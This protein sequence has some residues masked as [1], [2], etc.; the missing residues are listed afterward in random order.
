MIWKIWIHVYYKQDIIINNA[1]CEMRASVLCA[2]KRQWEWSPSVNA[3]SS[4]SNNCPP[5]RSTH[6]IHPQ[7]KN[8]YTANQIL[9]YLR[10]PLEGKLHW[11]NNFLGTQ[12]WHNIRKMIGIKNLTKPRYSMSKDTAYRKSWIHASLGLSRAKGVVNMW[13]P[14]INWLAIKEF[15]WARKHSRARQCEK[16]VR[17]H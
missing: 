11:H 4:S 13:P 6:H 3:L 12:N 14:A 17:A 15:P 5:A 7:E 2:V 10:H 8:K 1:S 9:W 16:C